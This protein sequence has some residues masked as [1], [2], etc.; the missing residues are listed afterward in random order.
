MKVSYEG[1]EYSVRWRYTKIRAKDFTGTLEEK[2]LPELEITRCDVSLVLPDKTG[3]ERYLTFATGMV[4]QK[5]GDAPNRVL[6]R[7]YSLD[8]ALTEMLSK[9]KRTVFWKAFTTE[10]RGPWKKNQELV[11]SH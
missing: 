1:K 7:K 9:E 8:K 2:E 3:R 11:A 4:G 6:A 5:Y 10:C